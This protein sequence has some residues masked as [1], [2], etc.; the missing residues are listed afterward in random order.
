VPEGDVETYFENGRWKNKVEGSARASNS[1]DTKTKARAKGREM[2]RQRRVE[3][4][5]RNL[6]GQ[7][8]ERNSYGHDPR[9]IPG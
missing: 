4:I 3:H 5:V 6:D 7:I 8:G 2:A 9:D 1:F